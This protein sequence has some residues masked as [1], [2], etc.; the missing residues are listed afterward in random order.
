MNSTYITEFISD[1]LDGYKSIVAI[2]CPIVFFIGACNV[3]INIIV[4]A[5]FGGGL[6]I[7]KKG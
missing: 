7:G 3:A 6:R 2:G 5:F 4:T 1:V